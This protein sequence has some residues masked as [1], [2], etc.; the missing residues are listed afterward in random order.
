MK[1]GERQ[2]Q[3]RGSTCVSSSI[4]L[5]SSSR[6][7]SWREHKHAAIRVSALRERARR[8]CRWGQMPGSFTFRY[9]VDGNRA[10][11]RHSSLSLLY[12]FF[13]SLSL[14]PSLFLFSF[15]HL[16]TS[17]FSLRK[18]LFP[19]AQFFLRVERLNSCTRLMH[20]DVPRPGKGRPPRDRRR[21]RDREET[22]TRTKNRCTWSFRLHAS[23]PRASSPFVI[24]R[25]IC[26]RR[27]TE[28]RPPPP[29]LPPRH[30]S[31]SPKS[32]HACRACRSRARQYSRGKYTEWS[33]QENS[34]AF[35]PEQVCAARI[36]RPAQVSRRTSLR[37]HAKTNVTG[38]AVAHT[39]DA[40]RR[41]L[42]YCIDIKII[43]CFLYSVSRRAFIY[44]HK[45]ARR[46]IKWS[47]GHFVSM[48]RKKNQT[49]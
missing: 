32:M 24:K 19:T 27:A 22:L 34:R 23:R 33:L 37:N 13:L 42:T 11:A 39:I 20:R 43:R 3:G 25:R 30:A 45:T 35:I 17:R 9:P 48:F 46:C 29:P 40:P 18:V 41:A 28:F 38:V 21:G 5:T 1:I 12:F 26:A 47:T 2:G 36:F 44:R 15:V 10:A 8:R 7:N 49:F 6:Q 16:D 31:A 4:S 14:S